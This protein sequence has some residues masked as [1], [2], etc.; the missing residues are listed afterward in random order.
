MQCLTGRQM[1]EAGQESVDL[2][3]DRGILAVGTDHVLALAPQ[4]IHRV[5]VGRPFGQRDQLDR[6]FVGQFHRA[7]RCVTG[8]LIQQQDRMPAS[9]PPMQEI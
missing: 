5:E 1:I 7:V 3:I 6:Q 9:I 4:P 8:V 2:I